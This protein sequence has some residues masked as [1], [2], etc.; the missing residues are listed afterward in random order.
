VSIFFRVL[1]ADHCGFRTLCLRGSV[2]LMSH[3]VGTTRTVFVSAN[4]ASTPAPPAASSRSCGV[5]HCNETVTT[6]WKHACPECGTPKSSKVKLCGNCNVPGNGPAPAAVPLPVTPNPQQGNA[7]AAPPVIHE[8]SLVRL[9]RKFETSHSVLYQSLYDGVSVIEKVPLSPENVRGLLK[10]AGLHSQ[11]DRHPNIIRNFGICRR[12][13]GEISMVVEQLEGDLTEHLNRIREQSDFQPEGW[14]PSLALYMVQV[15]RGL[16]H[17]HQTGI[18]H[19]DICANNVF[20]DGELMKVSDFG[21]AKRTTDQTATGLPYPLTTAPEVLRNM[22]DLGIWTPKADVWQFGLLLCEVF[23]F[24]VNPLKEFN[25]SVEALLEALDRGWVPAR[26]AL[27]PDP[28][29]RIIL[30]CV[31]QDHNVRPDLATVVPHLEAFAA[32]LAKPSG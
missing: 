27:C 29:W 1:T 31:E 25:V 13:D 28:L 9:Y 14:M 32:S 4:S 3:Y 19:R 2:L 23:S 6:C 5:P 20:T 26:P 15:A 12:S 21:L 11:A 24:G 16:R 30:M 18:I 22:N 10:E 8:A 17:L 7:G